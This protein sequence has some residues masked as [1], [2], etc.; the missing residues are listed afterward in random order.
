[1]MTK[2]QKQ[3]L[4]SIDD[5]AAYLQSLLGTNSDA[6]NHVARI[7]DYTKFLRQSLQ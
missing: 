6:R 4:N 3:W 2:E 5:E 7:W 1:M